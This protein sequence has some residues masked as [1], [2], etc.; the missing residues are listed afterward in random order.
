MPISVHVDLAGAVAN[1]KHR[2]SNIRKESDE[3]MK[4]SPMIW[5]NK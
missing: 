1:A 4:N 5:S 3:I 2:F